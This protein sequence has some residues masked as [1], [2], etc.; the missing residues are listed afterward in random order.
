M[1]TKNKKER[2]NWF[3]GLFYLTVLVNRLISYDF[4]PQKTVHWV[5]VLALTVLVGVHFFNA[6]RWRKKG[7]LP[8]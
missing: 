2:F 8:S 7:V 1:M 5:I 6:V 4:Y 3:F